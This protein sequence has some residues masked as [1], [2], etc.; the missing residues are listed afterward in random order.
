VHCD[1]EVFRLRIDVK[2]TRCGV[3]NMLTVLWLPLHIRPSLCRVR[4]HVALG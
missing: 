3:N 1:I 2:T 4:H